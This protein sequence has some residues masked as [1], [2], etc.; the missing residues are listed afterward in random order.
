MNYIPIFFVTFLLS[1]TSFSNDFKKEFNEKVRPL[2]VKYCLDCH[3]PDDEDNESPFLEAVE[4]EDIQK[5]RHAWKS[6]AAQLRNRTMPPKRKKK[7]PTEFERIELSTWIDNYLRQ[8]ALEMP[9][10]AGSITTRRLN[11]DEYNNTIRDLV[12]LDLGFADSFPVDGGGGEGFDNNGETLFLPPLLMERYLESAQLILDKAIILP[13]FKASF[14]GS[15]MSPEASNTPEREIKAGNKIHTL[16]TIS[17]TG[18]FNINLTV[19]PVEK[20]ATVVLKVDG[21]TAHKFHVGNDSK[22]LKAT[23]RLTREFILS[24]S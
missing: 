7:Q 24:L 12:G 18:N 3:D 22:D 6:T 20:K 23:I 21:I 15:K 1:L 4:L 19:K 11:R 5:Y 9:E 16:I 8:S 10:Y 2:L 17:K 13:Q 14:N